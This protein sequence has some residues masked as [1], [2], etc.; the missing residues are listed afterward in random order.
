MLH[1]SVSYPTLLLQ[2]V[3]A[4]WCRL[5]SGADVVCGA[6]E[7]GVSLRREPNLPPEFLT[8]PEPEIIESL[9]ICKLSDL[10]IFILDTVAG[11]YMVQLSELQEDELSNINAEPTAARPL[12]PR[13]TRFSFISL[14]RF[15]A[16]C[17]QIGSE[18]CGADCK[19]TIDY[20][21]WFIFQCILIRGIFGG[22]CIDFLFERWNA[23]CAPSCPADALATTFSWKLAAALSANY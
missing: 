4:C 20:C 6:R 9:G 11:A 16:D 2:Y 17:C 1:T 22:L 23:R 10:S 13:L 3:L 5:R 18:I 14:T 7:A 8:Q 19:P 15:L 12:D 21:P